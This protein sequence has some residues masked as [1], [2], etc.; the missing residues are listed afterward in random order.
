[1]FSRYCLSKNITLFFKNALKFLN[2]K[3]KSEKFD[4]STVVRENVTASRAG[5]HAIFFAFPD[6]EKFD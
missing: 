3:K 4:Y 2:D 6:Y 1:M 5:R